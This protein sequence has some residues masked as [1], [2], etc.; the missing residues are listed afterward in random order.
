MVDLWKIALTTFGSATAALAI[1]TAIFLVWLPREFDEINRNQ[2]NQASDLDSSIKALQGSVDHVLAS[3]NSGNDLLRS[4]SERQNF[5]IDAL[6]WLAATL[7]QNG[8]L[9]DEVLVPYIG[10]AS[11]AELELVGADKLLKGVVINGENYVFVELSDVAKF[12]DDSIQWL[13]S[14]SGD[15]TYRFVVWNKANFPG[16]G[17]SASSSD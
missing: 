3:T 14:V 7:D 12:P 9:L 11:L 1:P 6:G 4:Q 2:V 5:S 10:A 17:F 8:K 16:V 15:D 13:E